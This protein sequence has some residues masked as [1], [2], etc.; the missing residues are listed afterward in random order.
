MLVDS[1]G[2]VGED[3]LRKYVSGVREAAAAEWSVVPVRNA[4]KKCLAVAKH[5]LLPPETI[6]SALTKQRLKQLA[7]SFGLKWEAS[8]ETECIIYGNLVVLDIV[9][10]S[11]AEVSGVKLTIPDPEGQEADDVR[12][13]ELLTALLRRGDWSALE[14]AM[15]TLAFL[16][17]HD[18]F[19]LMRCIERDLHS[20]HGMELTACGND[21]EKVA[22]EGHGVP[23][24]NVDQLGPSLLY[25]TTPASRPFIAQ[26]SR[27]AEDTPGWYKAHIS[28][29]PS[30]PT[31]YPDHSVKQFLLSSVDVTG[32]P[33]EV[34]ENNHMNGVGGVSLDFVNLRQVAAKTVPARYALILSPPVVVAAEVG[35]KLSAEVG[36][37]SGVYEEHSMDAAQAPRY[38]TL[39]ELLV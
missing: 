13:S 22:L 32:A 38:A 18:A 28:L 11:N 8:A 36:L 23:S 4:M 39:D 14:K 27:S 37:S 12:A 30:A 21:L 17:K 15:S 16:D 33:T 29:E 24:F 20:I 6:G 3:Q 34:S 10:E 9:I 35:A 7:T 5:I 25:W 26:G 1:R 31:A 19:H 2:P